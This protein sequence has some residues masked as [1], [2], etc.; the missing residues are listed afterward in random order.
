MFARLV[1]FALVITFSAV[2]A[3]AQEI[4]RG[5]LKELDVAKK[6]IVITADGKDQSFEL[7]DS[8]RVLDATGD[9]LAEKLRDF[10][11]GKDIFF[12][13]QTADGKVLDGLRLVDAGQGGG[14]PNA[15]PNAPRGGNIQS[16]TIK[17]VDAEKKLVTI[18]VGGKDLE[19][20]VSDQT[21]FR[22]I[23]AASLDARLK[24]LSAGA[25]IMFIANTEANPPAL[26]A[27]ARN[28][29]RGGA[30]STPG[31]RVSPD[32]ASFQPLTELGKGKYQGHVGG[33][34]P[35]GQNERPSTHE[36]AGLRLAKL[37]QPLNTAGKA[38]PQGKVVLLSIG[39][40]NTSQISQGFERWLNENR[41]KVNE[42]FQFVNGAQGGQTAEAIINPDDNGRGQRFWQ[43][44]DERLDQARVTREQVQ[45]VWIK[46]A[47]GGPSQGFP[48]YARKL[49]AEL[50][51][52]AQVIA[53]RFP[54]CKLTYVSSR[55][56][57]GFA[58]TRLNPE[59]YAYESGFS[60]KWLIEQQLDGDKGLNFDPAKGP[61]TA[62]WLSWGPYLWVNGEKKRQ[63]GF[64]S[65]PGDFVAD[66]THHS[67]EGQRKMGEQLGI[68]F[69]GDSTTK[70]WFAK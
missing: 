37:V 8:T 6:S 36:Q 60:V 7:T 67:P 29:N 42:R 9:T 25:A 24:E 53:K 61:V 39:M 45:A 54:N 68:F 57:G 50:K 22:D 5:V 58:T 62:T 21:N 59:P 66:G 46:Q 47:D 64:S 69:L 70:S 52:I 27:I 17:N 35:D 38:D 44:V 15:P 20:T 10:R 26:V 30:P 43:V 12:R 48:G 11:T 63:D 1:A 31:E 40:S 65:S 14:R 4:R 3:P 41:N 18:T 32:H 34:Y 49:E 55:T 16:G 23:Q 28:G 2:V 33:L 19:L 13:Q 56:Y 51:T